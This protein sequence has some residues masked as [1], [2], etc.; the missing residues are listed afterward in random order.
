MT[1]VKIHAVDKDFE[2]IPGLT[3]CRNARVQLIDY[4]GY[5]V[6][7]MLTVTEAGKPEVRSLTVV[8]R[9]G[10]PPVTGTALR[11]IAIQSVVRQFVKQQIE[12]EHGIEAGAEVVALGL[13]STSEA[14][15][16]K[17]LG[18]QPETIEQVARVYRL[19]E[20]MSDAPTKA[21]ED[22][23]EV[24]RSTAGAWIGRAR[25]AGLIAPTPIAEEQSD[26]T[27]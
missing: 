15:Q 19:A 12:I 3:I 22:A 9:D 20:F 25:A 1:E 16:L 17:K 7:A 10:G 8:Q 27:T 21:I 5:D 14:R 24:S 4:R 13:L 11:S 18:P 6:D 26:A 23:F 2:V